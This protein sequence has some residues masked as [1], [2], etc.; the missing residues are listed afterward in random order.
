MEFSQVLLDLNDLADTGPNWWAISKLRA[1]AL[2]TE[3]FV[4]IDDDVFLWNPLP[5]RLETAQVFAQHPE[6]HEYGRSFY[7]PEFFEHAIYNQGGWLPTELSHYV[8]PSGY[9]RAENCGIL[10]GSN[11]DFINYYASQALEL[12]N[13]PLNQPVWVNLERKDNHFILIEQ[14]FLAAC[15]E[16]HK[17]NKESN[18]YGIDIEYLF[19]SYQAAVKTAPAMGFTHLIA[20][21]KRNPSLLDRLEQRVR[22]DYPHRYQRC[23]E[24]LE[25]IPRRNGEKGRLP[26]A[27]D[28]RSSR[29]DAAD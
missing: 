12:I 27:A 4:H 24:L 29:S 1:Y 13:H 8:H 10:G 6:W 23:L 20:S 26:D 14:Y 21:A 18:F 2:Q 15:I 16:F 28:P 17:N 7:K 19:P 11:I 3:P 22:T 9:L 5:Q 25:T